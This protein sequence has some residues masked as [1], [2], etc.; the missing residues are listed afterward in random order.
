MRKM[1]VLLKAGKGTWYRVLEVRIARAW[2]DGGGTVWDVVRR[3]LVPEE[4]IRDPLRAY[5]AAIP[6]QRIPA[7]TASC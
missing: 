2:V 4:Q 5:E 3:R 6:A 1:H 7:V